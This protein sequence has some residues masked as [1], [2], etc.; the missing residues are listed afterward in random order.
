MHS[1]SVEVNNARGADKLRFSGLGKKA[2][3]D[4]QEEYF[5][6]FLKCPIRPSQLAKKLSIDVIRTDVLSSRARIYI[7]K[8]DS[9]ISKYTAY[10]KRSLATDYARFDLAHE[11]GHVVLHDRYP[12]IAELSDTTSHEAFANGFASALLLPNTIRRLLCEK[13][14]DAKEPSDILEILGIVGLSLPALFA[15]L[16]QFPDWLKGL[17]NVW[18]RAKVM[19]HP[20]NQT[21]LKLRVERALYDPNELYLPLHQGL[22]SCCKP[23]EWLQNL[24]IGQTSGERVV[25]FTFWQRNGV[26][27]TNKYSKTCRVTATRGMRTDTF[28]NEP[29]EMYLVLV[30]FGDSG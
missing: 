11:I 1:R 8:S 28:E 25:D 10:V 4:L 12:G 27:S 21:G 17:S 29:S 22:A 13:I 3:R 18:L 15:A 30:R 23:I 16:G 20:T 26:G 7:S 19:N 2:A 24:A 6:L 9:Q 14:I 5:E